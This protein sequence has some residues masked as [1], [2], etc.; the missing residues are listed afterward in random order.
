MA[1][2]A[3]PYARNDGKVFET[4]RSWAEANGYSD[5][6]T[7]DRIDNDGNYEPSNCRWATQKEQVYNSQTVKPLLYKGKEV[8]LMDLAKE[9][10]HTVCQLTSTS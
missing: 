10:W 6:L 4:F 2:V 8:F 3:L 1:A 5:H 9:K 7:L